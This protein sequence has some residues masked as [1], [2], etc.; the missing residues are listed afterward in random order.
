MKQIF[1]ALSYMHDK[2]KISHRDIKPDNI[3]FSDESKS[4]IKIIDFDIFSFHLKEHTFLNSS[5][6]IKEHCE[7]R[8][9]EYFCWNYRL[10]RSRSC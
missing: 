6:H 4:E 7:F 3:L 5:K 2:H 9:E 10:L 1:S 8:D